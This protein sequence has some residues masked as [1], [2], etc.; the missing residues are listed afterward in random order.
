M[1]EAIDVL[2]KVV[3]LYPN[4]AYLYNNLGNTLW[5][6]LQ[7]EEAIAV[8]RQGIELTSDRSVL[9]S[10]Y[11]G[12]GNAL[13]DN[14]SFVDAI[15]A[16]RQAIAIKSDNPIPHFDLAIALSRQGEI[17]EAIR[18]CQLAIQLDPN[19]AAPQELLRELKQKQATR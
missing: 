19:A 11:T 5:A 2:T 14:G 4:R 15:D 16:Y 6:D 8:Y 17:D 3:E 10:L 7:F 13:D 9:S 18:E 12:L 1:S